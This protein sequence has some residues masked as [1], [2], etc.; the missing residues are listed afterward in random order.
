MPKGKWVRIVDNK[1]RYYGETDFEK[2]KIRVN[3]KKS[4]KN[5]MYKRPVNKHASRYPDL[6]GTIVHEE[7][8]RKHPKMRERTVR[9]IE[10]R[11]VKKLTKKQKRKYY[12]LY[13]KKKKK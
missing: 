1:M 3:K 9:K 11:M 2:K 10:R 13:R 12:N 7:T 5:P 6:L 8:H 4:K